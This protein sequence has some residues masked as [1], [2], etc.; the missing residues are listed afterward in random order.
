MDG[1]RIN[2]PWF[3]FHRGD[4]LRVVN[5]WPP[6]ARLAYFELLGVQWDEGKLPVESED[7]RMLV[8]GIAPKE[9]N[10]IWGYIDRVFP[11]VGDVRLNPAFDD[12]RQRR[13]RASRSTSARNA[14]QR[15]WHGPPSDA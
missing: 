14:A 3:K 4:Y 13:D 12:E 8:P 7:V 10:A 6:L 11:V 1:S 5:G 2:L 15:R 9:W